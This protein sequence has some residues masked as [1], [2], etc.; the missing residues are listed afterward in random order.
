[1]PDE[2]M[3]KEE[4]LVDLLTKEYEIAA[5]RYDNIYNATW[6]IFS[7][8]AIVSGG[9]LS[10]GAEA[11]DPWWVAGV[12]A[13]IPLIFWYF[14]SFIPLNQHGDRVSARIVNIERSLTKILGEPGETIE[15]L[16]IE[17]KRSG[18]GELLGKSDKVSLENRPIR[19]SH[20]GDFESRREKEG[21]KQ[22]EKVNTTGGPSVRDRVPKWGGGLLLFV[23]VVAALGNCS[24][25]ES[26]NQNDRSADATITEIRAELEQIQQGL[27]E[28]VVTIPIPSLEQQVAELRRRVDSIAAADSGGTE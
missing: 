23:F 22:L 16:I 24:G 17:P 13:C 12:I 18:L 19:I 7:Y 9:I 25:W 11:I 1:M 3:D 21:H 26:D 14:A 5:Q 10:F 2:P 8:M 20:F 15:E 6:R 28:G 27:D 4:K